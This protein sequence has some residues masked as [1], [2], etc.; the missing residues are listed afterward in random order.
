MLYSE[1]DADT[2]AKEYRRDM[3]KGKDTP[4]P[5]NYFPNNDAALTPPVTWRSSGNLMFSNWLN[6]FVYQ[7]TPYDLTRVGNRSADTR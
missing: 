2:L 4:L 1:Y 6:Y 3:E 5:Y 7:T